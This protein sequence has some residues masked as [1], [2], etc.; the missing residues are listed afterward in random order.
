MPIYD[1]K[2]EQLCVQSLPIC[3][4]VSS[5]PA[6]GEVYSMQ[7]YVMKVVNDLQ[8]IGSFLLFP[9]TMTLTLTIYN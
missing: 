8:E 9:P 7:H 4:N 5:N 6:Q 3:S 1:G 2:Y